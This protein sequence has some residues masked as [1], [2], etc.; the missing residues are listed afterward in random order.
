MYSWIRI[1][2]PVN[3]IMGFVATYISAL[4]GIGLG[5][6]HTEPLILSSIAGVCVFLV[7]SGGNI[8][9]DISDAETD[10]INHPDRPIPR[11]EITVRNAG[12]A[13]VM[14]FVI[15]AILAA[16][17]LN[18]LAGLVVITAIA[19]LVGYETRLK[20]TGL[21]GNLA[22]SLL[23]GMIFIFGGIAV[24]SVP[25]MVLLFLMAFLTNT[26]REIIKDVEDMKGDVNR[27][28]FPMQHGIKA[29]FLLVVLFTLAGIA[30]SLLTYA[31]G[32][33]GVIYLI[34]VIIAD[35]VF[36]VSLAVFS[37]SV[38]NSQNFSKL[39]MIL[40]LVAFTVGGVA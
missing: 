22:I 14:F 5:L 19:I 35:A 23:V 30:F 28:T 31:I 11:G 29:S 25:R 38:E 10:R 26:A 8:I 13:S 24:N 9:N 12:V 2:R 3:A 15:S 6:F 16:I 18:L 7:I 34:A 1:I 40:G 33:F 17:F 37:K 27:K 20:G 39:A 36:L 21:P 4:V 32:I